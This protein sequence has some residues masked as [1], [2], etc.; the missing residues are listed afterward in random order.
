MYIRIHIE[1]KNGLMN[2]YYLNYANNILVLQYNQIS[3]LV[4]FYVSI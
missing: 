1:K 3:F 2:C 4:M